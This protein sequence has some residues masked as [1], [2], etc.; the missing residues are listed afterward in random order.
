MPETS[1][2][3]DQ[4]VAVVCGAASGIGAAVA[5]GFGARGAHVVCLDRNEDGAR[6]VATAIGDAG[7]VASSDSLDIRDSEAVDHSLVRTAQQH[8]RLDIVVSTP[9]V[10]VRKRVLDYA[11]EELDRVIDLNLKG[12]FN[13]LQAAGRIMAAQQG[14]SII[15][16]SSIRSLVVE[17][18]Q[19]VYAATKS[20]IVQLVRALAAELGPVGVRVNAIAPGVVDTPLTEPIKRNADWYGAYADRNAL[21]RWARVDEMVGPAVFLASEAASYVTGTVLFV[22][23]GWTAIDGRFSPP[24]I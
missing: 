20:G 18:G 19:G 15:A 24:G 23:G 4:Q 14:G 8:D 6:E 13:V 5:Q 11:P 12:T 16:Y 22:D 2:R 9:S 21:G 1:F 3:L 10:N 7:G 17:P